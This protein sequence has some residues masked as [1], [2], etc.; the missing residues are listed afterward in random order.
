MQYY[1]FKL[2]EESKDL[3]TIVTPFG[4]YKYNRLPMGLK[5]SP[6]VAQEIMETTLQGIDC[7][8]YIDDI[9]AFSSTWEHHLSLL[10]NIL[11]RLDEVKL[12]VNPLKCS[13]GVKE[14]DWLG[15]WLTPNG[16]KPWSKKISAILRMTRPTNATELRSFIGAVNF[17]RNM[18]KGRA[19]VFAPLT[20]LSGAKKGLKIDWT[21]KCDKA[22]KQM[23]AL[24]AADALLY[25]PNH[26]TSLL[27]LKQI[28]LTTK[29][30]PSSNRTANLLLIGPKSST[31]PK[32]TTPLRK[33]SC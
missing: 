32:E 5:C 7:E 12:R 6:D 14:T 19:S 33:K 18:W 25:Y 3:C 11:K 8:C 4:K 13:W 23:K 26:N 29:W 9:G 21:P 30:V 24:M 20:A 1:S 2:D 15:Y 17:Y 16:L 22:F 28:L 31:V 27:S 10:D